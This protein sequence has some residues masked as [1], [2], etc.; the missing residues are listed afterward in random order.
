[1]LVIDGEGDSLT[2]SA[3]IGCNGIGGQVT[4]M[5]DE[6]SFGTGTGTMKSCGAPLDSLER[7]LITALENAVHW[8]V[9]G[10]TMEFED[11]SGET[12]AVFEIRRR[13]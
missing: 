2:Y 9:L 4:V 3:T 12:V 13:P 7:R 11:Q 1:M 8:Q 6:I 10:S 5:G